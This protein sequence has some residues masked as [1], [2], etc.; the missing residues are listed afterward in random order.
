MT[1]TSTKT[2]SAAAP[3]EFHGYFA[4]DLLHR[5][6]WNARD[7]NARKGQKHPRW[8]AVMDAFAL[9]SGYSHDLCRKFGLDPEEEVKR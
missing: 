2:A 6:V 7:R 8:V 1:D 3:F 5:A 9:G 4:E